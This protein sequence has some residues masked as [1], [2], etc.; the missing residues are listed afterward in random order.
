LTRKNGD[1]IFDCFLF[2]Y[3]FHQIEKKKNQ[4]NQKNKKNQ[5]NQK[6]SSAYKMTFFVYIT[7][8]IGILHIH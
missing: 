6:F 5:K 1:F 4:K 3:F 7:N 2:I 8:Q